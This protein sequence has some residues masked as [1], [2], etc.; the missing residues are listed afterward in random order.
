VYSRQI[1]GEIYEF[2]VSGKLVMNVLVM[3]DRQ[4]ETLWSQL[5]GRAIEGP[6]TGTELEYFPSWQTTWQDWR[7]R[8]P[9][10][11]ALVK[12]YVGQRDPYLSYYSD[13]RAG[14]IGEEVD[15]DRLNTKQFVVGVAIDDQAVA[16]PFSVLNLE[17]VVNYQVG[18]VPVLVVFDEENASGVVFDRRVD[19]QVLEFQLLEDLTLQDHLTGSLWDGPTGEA[20]DG[21]Y[22]GQSL[23]RVKST[24]SFWFGWKDFYPD[25]EVYRIDGG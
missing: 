20:I 6:L 14:V 17:P 11:L 24:S 1:D 19:G 7:T 5:L 4:T 13:S 2:G 18:D 8:H 22:A 10:T 9:D 3:Y 25:T 16:F 15:D 21:E 12:G 23:E